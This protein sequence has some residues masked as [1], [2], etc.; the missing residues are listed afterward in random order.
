MINPTQRPLTDKTQ[1]SQETDINASGGLES[2]IRASERPQNP[3]PLGSAMVPESGLELY[4]GTEKESCVGGTV[5]ATYGS[6]SYLARKLK[7]LLQCIG[8]KRKIAEKMEQMTISNILDY[9]NFLNLALYRRQPS[10][11]NPAD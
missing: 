6:V 10:L 11:K 9:K 3:R 4:A 7:H 1:H 8:K 2:A 5:K